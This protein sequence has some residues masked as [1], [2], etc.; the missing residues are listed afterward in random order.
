MA[1]LGLGAW[2]VMS[3]YDVSLW[4]LF[5]AAAGLAAFFLHALAKNQEHLLY[6]PRAMPQFVRPSDNPP[7]FRSPEEYR[8]PFE[9]VR[10]ETEDGERLH[11]WLLLAPESRARPTILFLHENAGNMGFRLPILAALY[12]RLRANILVLS[13]RGYGESTGTPGEEGLVTD[14][15][16]ALRFL[17]ACDRVDASRIVLFGRSLGGAVAIALATHADALEAPAVRAVVVENTFTSISDLVDSLFSFAR[18]FKRWLLRLRWH[19]LARVAQ[20]RVPILF[21]AGQ[22]DEVVPPSHM[23]ALYEAAR[24]ARFRTRV[25]FPL[26]SH[27][28]T[29][30]Q[31]GYYEALQSFVERVFEGQ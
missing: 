8:I 14:A 12:H 28:E 30:T 15:R 19:S 31:P 17:R 1:L 16:T 5:A 9:D 25:K 27:N 21:L 22:Q 6:M 20:V 2:Q 23:A 11:A 4:Y 13:Y 7:N 26:G 18:P 10:L 24:R 29:W 3:A